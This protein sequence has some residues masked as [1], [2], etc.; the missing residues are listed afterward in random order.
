MG[1]LATEYEGRVEFN[2]ISAEE[3]ANRPEE[4]ERFGDS[5]H[6]LVAFGPDGEEVA[7]LPGHQYGKEEIV[8]VIDQ[9]LTER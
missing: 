6:G 1:E 3:T 8:G 9:V 2:V 4:T 5:L 7:M